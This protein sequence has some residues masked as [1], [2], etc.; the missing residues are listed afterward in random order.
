MESVLSLSFLSIFIRTN[1]GISIAWDTLGG[2]TVVGSD[3]LREIFH[4]EREGL[5]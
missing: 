4:Q 2:H 5:A 3:E 1:G